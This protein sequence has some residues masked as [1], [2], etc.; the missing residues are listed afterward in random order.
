M[1]EAR[2]SRLLDVRLI[3]AICTI[4]GLCLSVTPAISQVLYGSVVGVV[5]DAQGATVPG[6]TVTIVNKETNLTRDT[7]TNAEGAYSLV[8][9]LAG[10]VRRQGLAARDSARAFGPTCPSP[11]ARSARVDM[12]L[13]VGTVTETVTVA[14]RSAAAADRQGGRAAPS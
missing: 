3:G 14:S 11:S 5:K 9:V 2:R 12:A 7:V 4:L 6:A 10:A 13:E 8:N 1:S